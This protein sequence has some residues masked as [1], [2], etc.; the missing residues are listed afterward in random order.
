MG[1]S[2]LLAVGNDAAVNM[3]C[4]CLFE[5]LLSSPLGV[6]LTGTLLVPKGNSVS[7]C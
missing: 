2:H 3:A 5:S 4:A 7:D 6:N 1:G